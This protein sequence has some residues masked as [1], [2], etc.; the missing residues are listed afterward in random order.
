MQVKQFHVLKQTQM[1]KWKK[2]RLM[3]SKHLVQLGGV[4][5][6]KMEIV[7]II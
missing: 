1:Q 5:L 7:L 2:V 4:M 3:Q 6:N